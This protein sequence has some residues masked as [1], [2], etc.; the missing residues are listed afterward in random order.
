MVS[1]ENE[2][3]FRSAL[4]KGIN[5]F[6]GAGFSVLAKNKDGSHLPLGEGLKDELSIILNYHRS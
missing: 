3:N 6:L 4:S 1:I 2:N 5:L